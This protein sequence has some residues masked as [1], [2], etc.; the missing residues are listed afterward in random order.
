MMIE[1]NLLRKLRDEFYNAPFYIRKTRWYTFTKAKLDKL[2]DPGP[3]DE[4]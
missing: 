4:G 1:R 2:G 3:E